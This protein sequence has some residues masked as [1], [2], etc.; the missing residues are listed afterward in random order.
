MRSLIIVVV[1]VV[2]AGGCT[3][4]VV[5]SGPSTPPKTGM[6]DAPDPITDGS[7]DAPPVDA[8]PDAAIDAP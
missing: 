1:V 2:L 4:D 7:I 3:R 6:P 8:A 5:L